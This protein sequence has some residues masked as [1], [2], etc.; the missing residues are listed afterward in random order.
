MSL[1]DPA[2][3][4]DEDRHLA[5]EHNDTWL[6]LARLT[7]RENREQ[8]ERDRAERDAAESIEA[9]EAHWT[10]AFRAAPK[11]PVWYADDR[12]HLDHRLRSESA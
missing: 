12:G 6:E 7:D 1:R 5:R 10:G 2:E 3:E 11:E 4:R 8:A 9:V